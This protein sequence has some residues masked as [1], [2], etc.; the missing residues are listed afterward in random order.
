MLAL[1]FQLNN[2]STVKRSIFGPFLVP[3]RNRCPRIKGIIGN[4]YFSALVYLIEAI[5]PL[6][7][8][9]NKIVVHCVNIYIKKNIN[10]KNRKGIYFFLAR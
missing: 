4:L 1:S 3:N 6:E 10:A 7:P 8:L 9:A 2:K 5:T